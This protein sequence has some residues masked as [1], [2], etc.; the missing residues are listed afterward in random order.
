MSHAYRCLI[1]LTLTH[2]IVDASAIVVGPLWGEL[3]RVHSLTEN[4]LFIVLTIHALASSLAQPVFGYI[5]DRYPIKSILWIGPVLGAVM[6]PMV[7]PAN[8]VFVLCVALLLGGIGIGSF[9]PEAAVV[10]GSLIP[11]RRTRSLSLFMFGGAMG[12]AL[13][14]IICGSIVSI[15][16]LASVWILAPLYSGLILFLYQLGKPPAELF[17]RDRKAPAQSLSQMLEGRVL[18]ALFLFMVCSLRLVPNMAMDKLISFI[19]KNHDA[20]AFEIGMVQSVFL[21]SASAGMLL[22]A[23]RFKS[24]HE[25]AFM[26][27]CPLL[28]I[29]LMFVLGWEGCPTWLMTLLLI[30]SGLILWGTSP[31]MVSYSH[32]LFPKGGGV[33]SAITM[34]MAWGGGGMIQAKITSHFVA[35]GIPHKA[36]HAIIPCLILAT[37]GAVLLPSLTSKTESKT[38]AIET[39]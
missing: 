27:G 30:P 38:E 25:K 32:Q 26:I 1:C 28:G 36:F 29:P 6:M 23:F 31:A 2:I 10:A 15:W 7:G 37:I 13:G 20:S 5:R 21:F 14:P 33:A 39:A 4:S 17:E 18:L 19:L 8:S 3:E 16:G 24:G 34:G 22:M 35:L 12:L 11:E 9:H